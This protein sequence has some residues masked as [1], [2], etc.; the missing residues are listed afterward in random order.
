MFFGKLQGHFLPRQL[1]IGDQLVEAADQFAHIARDRPGQEIEHICRYFERREAGKLGCEDLLAQFDIGCLDIGHQSHRETRKQARFHAVQSLGRAVCGKYQPLA[2]GQQRID[3][4][5]EFF[6]RAGLADDELDVIHQQ[7]VETTQAGLEF[8]HLVGLQRLDEFDHE[9]F[10]AAVENA[11]AR[12]GL[13]EAVAD[14]V[15]QMRLALAR[16]GLEI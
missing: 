3:R 14:R 10:G 9:A 15:E 4:I 5:E 7:Q 6:L 12:M 2:F 1:R 13:Q 16:S 11:A 8:Q